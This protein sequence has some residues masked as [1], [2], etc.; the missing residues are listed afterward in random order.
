MIHPRKD[1][2]LNINQSSSGLIG[3]L[4]YL[5]IV[6]LGRKNIYRYKKLGGGGEKG[7]VHVCAYIHYGVHI[8][9]FVWLKFVFVFFSCTLSKLANYFDVTFLVIE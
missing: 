8:D 7:S 2:K 5:Y 6:L 3:G 1:N 9:T 4:K